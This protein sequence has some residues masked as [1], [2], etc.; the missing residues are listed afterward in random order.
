MVHAFD[1]H[2]RSFDVA[3]WIV[4]YP[5]MCGCL[6]SQFHTPVFHFIHV[7]CNYKNPTTFCSYKFYI[8]VFDDLEFACLANDPY[9]VWTDR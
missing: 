1:S 7:L 9:G 8:I 4:G 6:A 5:V 2:T 3:S